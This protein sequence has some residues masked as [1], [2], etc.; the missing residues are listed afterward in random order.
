MK[1]SR[2]RSPS[3]VPFV[4][5]LVVLGCVADSSID[6]PVGSAPS[7]PGAPSASS[8]PKHPAPNDGVMSAAA[9]PTPNILNA[10]S[11]GLNGTV[12]HKASTPSTVT[13][14]DGVITWGGLS[15][16]TVSPPNGPG[17]IVSAP[18]FPS[19]KA[20]QFRDGTGA[21]FQF[22][23]PI[24]H[25]NV[26]YVQ[27]EISFGSG[28]NAPHAAGNYKLIRTR[29][30]GYGSL[31][32]S[33]IVQWNQIFGFFDDFEASPGMHLLLP[34]ITVYNDGRVHTLKA[35]FEADATPSITLWIDGVK[36]AT[37]TPTNHYT[38]PPTGVTS[39]IEMFETTN[40]AVLGIRQVDRV[41]ISTQDIPAFPTLSTSG[42]TGVVVPPTGP[43][44]PDSSSV[45]TLGVGSPNIL[46]AWS[47]GLNGTVPHAPSTPSTFTN[48]DGVVTWGVSDGSPVGH[49]RHRA[50]SSR[51]ERRC[52]S[53][54]APVQTSSSGHR[55]RTP[56]WSTSSW[57]CLLAAGRMR[58][59]RAAISSSFAPARRATTF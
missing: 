35:R 20:M 40:N 29:S 53:W 52:S 59:T 50:R 10:W 9:T 45:P 39:I 19:G 37:V 15:D 26:V 6:G 41:S 47:L 5:M 38:V 25:T 51:V 12:P 48:P 16:P 34:D 44:T 1:I 31:N 30:K 11:L 22:G 14:P 55:S 28:G 21:D 33:L 13:N 42:S 4:A 54:T 57:R 58:R 18:Q 43:V 32:G 49:D 2:R 27:V 24:Q 7:K 8:A 46:N 36:K 17:T 23:S 56:T 3:V